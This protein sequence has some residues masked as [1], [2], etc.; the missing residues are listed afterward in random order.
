[1]ADLVDYLDAKYRIVA[2]Q[3]DSP[4]SITI[5]ILRRPEG[6]TLAPGIDGGIDRIVREDCDCI[7]GCSACWFSGSR[8]V[9]RRKPTQTND[10]L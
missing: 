6:M 3:H 9:R 7:N 10:D 4:E 1:M 8:E 5:C 2:Y